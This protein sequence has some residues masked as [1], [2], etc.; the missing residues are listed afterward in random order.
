MNYMYRIDLGKEHHY[1]WRELPLSNSWLPASMT[2]F[3]ISASVHSL[4]SWGNM[5]EHNPFSALRMKWYMFI[6]L[7]RPLPNSN[8]YFNQIYYIFKLWLVFIPTMKGMGFPARIN[9]SIGDMT[10]P[11]GAFPGKDVI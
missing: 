4:S 8:I 10:E 1:I 7:I 5:S 9:K 3:L 11:A 6:L 2:E